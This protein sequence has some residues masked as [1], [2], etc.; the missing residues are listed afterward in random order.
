MVHLRS[1]LLL[2]G[3]RISLETG[4]EYPRAREGK[5]QQTVQRHHDIRQKPVKIGLGAK[6]QRPPLGSRT[7]FQALRGVSPVQRF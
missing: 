2:Y 7:F 4:Q 1:W 3:S 6:L 5:I